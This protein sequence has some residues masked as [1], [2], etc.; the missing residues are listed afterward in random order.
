MVVYVLVKKVFNKLPRFIQPLLRLTMTTPALEN[1]RHRRIIWVDG[2]MTGLEVEKQ[3]LC[4]IACV[5]TEADLTEVAAYGSV[6][7]GQSEEVIKGMSNWCKKTFKKNGLTQKI[8]ESKVTEEQ[9]E[10]ELLAFLQKHTDKF[11]CPL[12]G[13]SVNIDRLFIEKYLP[14]V[15]EHLHYRT[16]DVSTIKELCK[17]WNVDIYSKAPE[18][19]M[20]HRALDDIYESI[21]EL[22]YYKANLFV[23]P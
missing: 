17:R 12:A 18:K 23:K 1:T 11:T 15:G 3:R 22:R 7:I 21:A 8:R 10:K 5:I 6:V 4:E 13:N 2:E 19:T 9:V 16:I 14:K 20:C